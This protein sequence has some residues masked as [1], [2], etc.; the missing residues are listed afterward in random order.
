[1]QPPWEHGEQ[2]EHDSG[3]K[4]PSTRR[5]VRR[6]HFEGL[7]SRFS[8][9]E[10]TAVQ[11]RLTEVWR[12]VEGGAAPRRDVVQPMLSSWLRLPKRKWGSD[13]VWTERA[14]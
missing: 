11:R 4:S 2:L 7:G 5:D 3:V 10:E 8:P 13:D 9:E 1:V 14:G 12:N 6:P